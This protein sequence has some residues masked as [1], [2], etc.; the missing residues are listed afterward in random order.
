MIAATI[1]AIYYFNQI[2]NGPSSSAESI[3]LN[4]FLEN[5]LYARKNN[6]SWL[7]SSELTYRDSDVSI[8]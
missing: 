5:R 6:A 7:S 1:G 8:L 4:E 2:A 3:T